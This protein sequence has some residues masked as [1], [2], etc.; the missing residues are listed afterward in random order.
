LVRENADGSDKAIALMKERDNVYLKKV[1]GFEFLTPQDFLDTDFDAH[2]ENP[3]RNFIKYTPCVGMHLIPILL[4]TR[5]LTNQK[6]LST[7]VANAYFSDQR[8]PY[9]SF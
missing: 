1:E 9:L 6:R 8:P 3:D 7:S 2:V 5:P 4:L